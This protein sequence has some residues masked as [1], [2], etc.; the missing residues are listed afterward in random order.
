M[1]INN[2]KMKLDIAHKSKLIIGI[3]GGHAHNTNTQALKIAEQT[4]E[5]LARLGIAVACGGEDGI[6]E[7]V[8]RGAK[9]YGGV[10]IVIKNK[11]YVS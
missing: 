9:K 7:S 1:D 5:K 8:C 3:I 11:H 6:M 10:T 4:G 2:T